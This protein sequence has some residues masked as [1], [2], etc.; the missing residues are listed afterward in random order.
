M[1]AEGRILLGKATASVVPRESVVFRDG[2]AYLFV[3]KAVDGAE[4]GTGLQRVEQRR[5]DIGSRQGE[6]TEILSGL[7]PGERVVR[8]GAGFLGNGDLVREV[9]ESK[10]GATGTPQ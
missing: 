10:D 1:F 6:V 9:S 5:V 4:T 3:P 2:F 8:R 7:A